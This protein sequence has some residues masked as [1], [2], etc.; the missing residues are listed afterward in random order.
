MNVFRVA[1]IKNAVKV[2]LIHNHPSGEVQPSLGDEELTDRLIQCG[3]IINVRVVDHMIITPNTYYSFRNS[4]LFK[5]LEESIRWVPS[6]E[7]VRKVREEE[8]QL[9]NFYVE[10]AREEG[11]KKGLEKGVDVGV[12][13]G[14][15][16]GLKEGVEKGK[17]SGIKKG[18]KEE[19]IEIAK[20]MKADGKS[21]E[22]IIKYTKLT[23]KEIE[24]L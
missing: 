22:E 5:E 14:R 1:L 3:R 15:K 9:R 8:R 20:D 18:K 13:Q 6:A 19:K 12:K 21:L 4:G 23:Q 11:E 2:V 7:A 16:E 10:E 17:K 24:K